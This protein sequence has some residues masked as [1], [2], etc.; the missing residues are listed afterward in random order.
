M[1]EITTK[2]WVFTTAQTDF[3]METVSATQSMVVWFVIA[4]CAHSNTGDV[5]ARI[6]CA[7]ATL[8]TISN[9]SATGGVGIA[10][11]HGGIAPGSGAVASLGGAPLVVGAPDADLRVT[12]AAA[13]GGDV[14]FVVGYQ[15]RDLAAPA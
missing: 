10:F 13:T 2:E 14:R 9:N 6:G 5:H 11:T 8:P 3:S 15:L 7:T 1:I 4:T 12:C